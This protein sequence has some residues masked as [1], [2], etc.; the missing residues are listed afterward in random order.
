MFQKS[1][2][3]ILFVLIGV[4]AVYSQTPEPKNEKQEAVR[5]M[6]WSFDSDGGYLGIQTEEVNREN[7]TKYGLREVRG[8]GIENVIDG[9]PAQAAGLQKG[10]VIVRVNGDEITSGMKLSRLINEISPDH[11]AR[12]TVVRSGAER[13]ITVTIGKRPGFKFDNGAFELLGPTGRIDIPR[14]D[15]P[16]L[17]N[18]PRIAMPPM[19]PMS[20]EPGEPLMQFFGSRRQ[21][22]VSLTPLTKQLAD[23]FGVESGALVNN[24]RDNSAAAKA[25]IKAGDVIIEVDGKPVKGEF[26]LIRAISE[27]RDGSLTLTIVRD[28][29]RQTISVTPEEVK[30]VFDNHFEF[31]T[32]AAP[33]APQ[34]PGV[35][36]MTRPVVPG[37]PPVPLPLDQYLKRGRVI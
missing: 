13:E 8:V 7:F 3:F 22:G 25:G 5:A 24:V 11:Q 1:F 32:P 28:R 21:I 17:E 16:S 26:D 33:G 18:L 30:G 4:G 19:P 12:L 27:K 14:I 23:H 10:D 31:T 6:T 29:N 35:L 15:M 37:P 2:A 20:G 36:R 34:A 9:S